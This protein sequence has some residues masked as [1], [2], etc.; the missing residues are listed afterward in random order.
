[1]KYS[2]FIALVTAA[3][4]NSAESILKKRPNTV[5]LAAKPAA[6]PPGVQENCR[7]SIPSCFEILLPLSSKS[8]SAACCFLVSGSGMNSSLETTCGGTVLELL[9]LGH[10]RICGLRTYLRSLSIGVTE[11]LR[12][13][14]RKWGPPPGNSDTSFTRLTF[15]VATPSTCSDSQSASAPALRV[16]GLFSRTPGPTQA[17]PDRRAL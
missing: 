13:H 5:F 15:P 11:A 2:V 12:A 16:P 17:C 9:M 10:P 14:S 4:Y 3:S 8:L 1:M 6:I 7:R